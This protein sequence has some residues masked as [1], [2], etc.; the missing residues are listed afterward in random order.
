MKMLKAKLWE[1]LFF[2]GNLSQKTRM[3]SQASWK[4]CLFSKTT[5]LW[6]VVPVGFFNILTS[7]FWPIRVQSMENCCWFVNFTR[8]KWLLIRWLVSGKMFQISKRE[9]RI[10]DLLSLI[11]FY[12][13]R[14]Q[15]DFMKYI[16]RSINR[17]R[18][19]VFTKVHKVCSVVLAFF[20]MIQRI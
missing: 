6:L 13:S 3:L 18:K 12:F 10:I 19:D 9:L 15:E 1:H 5:C 11:I 16:K 8:T 4:L 2:F 20:K 7:Y 17:Y 14:T